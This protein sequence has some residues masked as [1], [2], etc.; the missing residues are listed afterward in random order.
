MYSKKITETD[1]FLSLPLS[2]QALYFHLGMNADDDGFV[3]SPMRVMRMIGANKNELDLLLVKGYLIPFDGGVCV[4]KHWRINNY[5]RSDRYTPTIYSEEKAT[6][7]QLENGVYEKRENL[8]IPMVDQ[9]SPQDSI[10]KDSIDIEQC[11]N[12]NNNISPSSTDDEQTKTD[13]KLPTK[14]QYI[15]SLFE[16]IWAVYPKKV[17]KEQAKKTWQKKLISC[18]DNDQVLLKAKKIAALLTNH[19]Q[20]WKVE[21]RELSYIPHFSSWLNSEIPDKEV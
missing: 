3:S 10:G 2:T 6:L 14:Q 1:D 4:I 7:T 11:F 17:S 5:L 8:G 20:S 9:V 18:K 21:K 15:S 19:K 16:K 12:I 13:V